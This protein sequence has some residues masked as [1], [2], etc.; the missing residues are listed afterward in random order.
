MDRLSEGKIR[1]K[2]LAFNDPKNTSDDDLWDAIESNEY[3]TIED[4][5]REKKGVSFV[6]H[7]VHMY[8]KDTV[9]GFIDHMEDET[10]MTFAK[11]L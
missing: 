4:F 5:K 1:L 3:I 2:G 7:T 8:D 10:S 6:F 9:Q 11:Y